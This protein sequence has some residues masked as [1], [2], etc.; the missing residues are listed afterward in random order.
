[1]KLKIAI[2]HLVLSITPAEGDKTT[3][4]INLEI[5][6]HSLEK[7]ILAEDI[8]NA[9]TNL[10]NLVNAAFDG[11]AKSEQAKHPPVIEECYM[12]GTRTTRNPES[13]TEKSNRLS[14]QQQGEMR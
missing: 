10:I 3:P 8:A 14:D 5:K 6:D 9:G 4:A 12:C 7:E 11:Y 2:A 13:S 1:M